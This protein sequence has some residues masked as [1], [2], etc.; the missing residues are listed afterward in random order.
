MLFK[1]YTNKTMEVE[2][3]EVTQIS[4]DMTYFKKGRAEKRIVEDWKYC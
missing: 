3:Q 2:E 1:N 4:D